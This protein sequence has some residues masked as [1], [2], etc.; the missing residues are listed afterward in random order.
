MQ[1][2]ITGEK[3]RNLLTAVPLGPSLPASFWLCDYRAVVKKWHVGTAANAEGAK[4][5]TLL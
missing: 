2:E 3:T 1:R 5:T 4:M